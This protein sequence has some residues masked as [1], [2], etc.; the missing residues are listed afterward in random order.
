MHCALSPVAVILN[1][2][3]L[4]GATISKHA[5]IGWTRRPTLI[6]E[7][8]A[9]HKQL[10]E[11]SLLT[12]QAR[13]IW[14]LGNHDARYETA[15][16]N[17]LP[18][19][20]EV[21]GTRLKDHFPDWEPAWSVWINNEINIKHRFK[22][23]IHA[24]YNNTKDSGVT[25]VTGHLHRLQVTPWSDY[26]GTRWGVETGMLGLPYDEPFVHYTEGSPCNWRGG[27]PVLSFMDGELLEP[28][29]VVSRTEKT[30]MFRG[31]IVAF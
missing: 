26:H 17:G 18:E 22:G 6:D 19:F 8:K 10:T 21:Q 14:T 11:I 28:E 27:F 20:Q 29:L 2:D 12:P 15:I 1:G 3:I 4:D 5:R 30:A 25:I 9:V 13:H 23:G 7:L 24:A 16:A 31:D